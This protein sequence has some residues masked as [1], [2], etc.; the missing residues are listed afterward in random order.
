MEILTFTFQGT[1]DEYI[2][3]RRL[4]SQRLPEVDMYCD[5]IEEAENGTFEY[6]MN[7]T[8]NCLLAFKTGML[9]SELYN[10]FKH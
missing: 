4:M 5:E 9:L 7:M 1:D 8:V 3:F 6:N 2:I 10:F